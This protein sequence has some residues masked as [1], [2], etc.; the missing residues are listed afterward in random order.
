MYVTCPKMKK[1]WP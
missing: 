1:S